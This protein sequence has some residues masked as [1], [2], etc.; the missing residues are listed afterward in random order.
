[1]RDKEQQDEIDE[2]PVK[3]VRRVRDEMQREFKSMKAL[4][5]FIRKLE[6]KDPKCN[7]ALRRKK[8]S[9]MARRRV[10]ELRKP[11]KVNN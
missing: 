10:A 4:Y 1:M 9:K 8:K 2:D 11:R 3:M 5:E 7:P 6:R